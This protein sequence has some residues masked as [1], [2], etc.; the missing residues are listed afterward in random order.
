MSSDEG[1]ERSIDRS[2]LGTPAAKAL[3]A[4]TSKARAG[5]IRELERLTSAVEAG[6]WWELG[7]L[8]QFY[9]RAG[10]LEAAERALREI[11]ARSLLRIANLREQADDPRSAEQ[12]RARARTL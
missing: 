2:S 8:A 1:L 11:A 9:E 12:W 4:R 5:N 3:R 6:E 10:N 7:A